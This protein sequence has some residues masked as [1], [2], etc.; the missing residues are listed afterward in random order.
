MIPTDCYLYHFS[1]LVPCHNNFLVVCLCV[2]I[3]YGIVEL[4]RFL[5]L[6][7]RDW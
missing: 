6:K 4:K 3:F 5:Y 1:V 7:A 2:L